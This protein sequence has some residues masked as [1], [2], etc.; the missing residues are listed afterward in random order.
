LQ[1]RFEPPLYVQQDPALVGVVSDRFEN[2]VPPNAIEERADVHID[3][4]R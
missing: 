3:Q 2:K 4:S 1:R